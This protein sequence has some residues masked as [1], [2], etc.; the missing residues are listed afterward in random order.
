M[1]SSLFLFALSL[2]FVLIIDIGDLFVKVLGVKQ[3][4]EVML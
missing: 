4:L 3:I 2:I 1:A